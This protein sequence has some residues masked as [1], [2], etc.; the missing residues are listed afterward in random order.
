MNKTSGTGDTESAAGLFSDAKVILQS[1]FPDAQIISPKRLFVV[2]VGSAAF[3]ARF[4]FARLHRPD[5]TGM[6]RMQFSAGTAIELVD[7]WHF[8][9]ARAHSTGPLNNSTNRK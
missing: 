7:S 5:F 1:L 3:A 6:C 4:I 2:F 9:S 8:F